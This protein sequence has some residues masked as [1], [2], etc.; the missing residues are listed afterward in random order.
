[1][2]NAT[3]APVVG[4]YVDFSIGELM[5]AVKDGEITGEFAGEVLGLQQQN[6]TALAVRNAIA[7]MPKG[8]GRG[9]TFKVSAK[10][11]MSIYGLNAKW[12]ITLYSEQIDRLFADDMVRQVRE[13]RELNRKLLSVKG[14]K[15]APTV[16][17]NPAAK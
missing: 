16:T 9:I 4:D 7:V 15:P 17:A 14:N 6:A 2:A 1:M 11:A 13:F 5:R 3:N 10:G 8:G 12:P